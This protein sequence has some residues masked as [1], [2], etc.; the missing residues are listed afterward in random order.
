[1]QKEKINGYSE[2]F[3]G[4]VTTLELAKFIE[5]LILQKIS[6]INIFHLTNSEKISK[7]SLIKILNEVFKL[8]LIVNSSSEYKVDKSL[9]NSNN[10]IDYKVPSYHLMMEEI[11]SWILVNKD[12]YPQYN[13]K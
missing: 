11:Y 1:M 2:A 3:W 9:I 12:L 7:L 10:T 4:G 8:K 6:N 5:F 13:I